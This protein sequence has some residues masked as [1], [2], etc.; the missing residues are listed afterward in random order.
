MPE[1][2]KKSVK[3]YNRKTGKSTI[4]HFFLK[5]TS[6]KELQRIAFDKNANAKLRMKCKKELTRRSHEQG[7]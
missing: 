4:E 6:T 7:R 5:Q 2:L 1:K 3:H